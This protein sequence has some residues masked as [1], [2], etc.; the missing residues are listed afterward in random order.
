[1]EFY[2]N[3]IK[4]VVFTVSILVLLSVVSLFIKRYRKAGLIV[5]CSIAASV[6]LMAAYYLSP[7]TYERQYLQQSQDL[8]AISLRQ[9]AERSGFYLGTAIS[10]HQLGVDEVNRSFNSLTPENDL[11]LGLLI[12]D[13]QIGV[14]DFSTADSIVDFAIQNNFRIRGHTLVWG[15][16]SSL[17]K[18]PDLDAYLSD[19]PE[20]D[21]SKILKDLVESHITTVLTRYQGK[22][23]QWDVV[24]EPL[25][26]LGSGELEENVFYRYLGPGYIDSAFRLAHELDPDADLFLNELLFNYHDGRAEAYYELVRKMK[27][28]GIPIHGVGFQSHVLY[29]LPSM[30]NITNY[31]KKFTDLGLKVEFTEVDARLRLFNDYEDPYQAQADFYGKLL[32]VC[33]DNP[34]CSGITFWGYTD[35]VCW[36]NENWIFPEPNEPFFFDHELNPKPIIGNLYQQFRKY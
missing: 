23:A 26:I 14:Y 12:V 13:K 2:I 10:A 35:A 22:I 15:K 25:E 5:L 30:D 29:S 27:E 21:R 18:H 19:F 28:D 36:L 6:L 17:F 32:E 20:Q 33:L 4:V 24:N 16:L 11:K 31:I 9:E 3:I 34:G 8:S 7:R 1:M